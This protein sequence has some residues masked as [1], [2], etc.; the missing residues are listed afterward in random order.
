ME[1]SKAVKVNGFLE[2]KMRNVYAIGDCIGGNLLAHSAYKDAEIATRNI[3][4]EEIEKGT[5]AIPRVV[6]TH[7]ELASVGFSEE[8]A[9]SLNIDYKVSRV[10]FASNGRAI[11]TGKTDGNI[12]IIHAKEGRIIGCIIVGESASELISLVS[13][14][15][16]KELS[17]KK[18]SET[19]FPHPTF[20]E[21]I[22]EVSTVAGVNTI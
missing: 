17:V 20:S 4:G 5:F 15:M 1:G 9:Q 11:A 18:L 14:A 2:T 7:P 19:V 21:V 13:L 16:D 6:Y 22:G 8:K 10:S 3:F 12:K